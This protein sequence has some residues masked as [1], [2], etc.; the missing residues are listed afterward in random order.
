M[1]NL[2]S[3]GQFAKLCNTTVD[4]LIHYETI[5]LLCPARKSGPHRHRRLYDIGL[6]HTFD[7]IQTMSEAGIPLSEIKELLTSGSADRLTD[8]IRQKE[9]LLQHQLLRIRQTA[10]YFVQS[11]IQPVLPVNPIFGQ[12]FV[13][14]LDE[15][16]L[17]FAT[18]FGYFPISSADMISAVTYHHNECLSHN[19]YPYPIGIILQKK[20]LY[21]Q[22][23]RRM[24]LYSPYPNGTVTNKTPVQL[25][26]EYAV[27]LHKGSF[28]SIN[29]SI[30]LLYDFIKEHHYV[31]ASDT[32]IRFYHNSLPDTMESFYL[33]KVRFL[34]L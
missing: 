17:L 5:G 25:S 9:S 18:L 11:Q 13:Q 29:E 10:D 15:N 19:T 4:T 12:P 31:V 23:N 24:L 16:I 21:A 14:I 30:E 22:N 33:I 27:I 32:Y 26:G 3:I 20:S 2:L 6:Y 1:Q 28:E 7:T 34:R 8:A